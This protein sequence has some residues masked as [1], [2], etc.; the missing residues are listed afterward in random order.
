MDNGTSLTSCHGHTSTTSGESLPTDVAQKSLEG[1]RRGLRSNDSNVKPFLDKQPDGW[2][3][4]KW[5]KE[6]VSLSDGDY[7]RNGDGLQR[8][9]KVREKL[10]DVKITFTTSL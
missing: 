2:H 7:Q 3:P 8:G 10:P 1:I 4:V 9:G 5:E 6:V